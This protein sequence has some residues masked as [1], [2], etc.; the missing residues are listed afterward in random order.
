MKMFDYSEL[1]RVINNVE[2][3]EE[4]EKVM[5]VLKLKERYLELE[6]S[7]IESGIL[8]DWNRLKQLCSKA[9]V[10]LCVSHQS[11]D[12]MGYVLGVGDFRYGSVYQ[13]EGTISKCVSNGSYWSDYYG[14]VYDSAK[15]IIWKTT[16]TTSSHG[17]EGFN[18]KQDE[19]MYLTRIELLESFR[20]TYENYRKFQLQKIEDKFANRIKMEDIIK[21]GI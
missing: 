6:R 12:S 13:D 8:D 9:K 5:G 14:F 1:I 3:R 11:N 7:L 20:D 17:F 15:G 18:E 21:G 10:R 19:K 2:I 4:H 16:H